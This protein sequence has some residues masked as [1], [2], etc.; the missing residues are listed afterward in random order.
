[1]AEH[2]YADS[3]IPLMLS[4]IILTVVTL[5]VIVLTVMAP[6]LVFERK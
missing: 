2:C 6:N 5:S 3:H 4:F 1:M